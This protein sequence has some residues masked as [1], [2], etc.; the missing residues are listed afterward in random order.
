[1]CACVRMCVRACVC[2]LACVCVCVYMHACV[3]VRVCMCACACVCLLS[4]GC[5][6][7]LTSELKSEPNRLSC[8]PEDCLPSG[9]KTPLTKTDSLHSM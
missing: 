6:D 9:G 8:G 1:M 2:V 7:G 5:E 4:A 3:C